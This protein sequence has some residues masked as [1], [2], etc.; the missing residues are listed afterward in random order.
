MCQHHERF[1][2]SPRCDCKARLVGQC[3]HVTAVLLMLSNYILENGHVVEKN[4]NIIALFLEQREKSEKKN[5]EIS[6]V[7]V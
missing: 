3:S 4:I 6:R 1:Y 2:K 7:D 5:K